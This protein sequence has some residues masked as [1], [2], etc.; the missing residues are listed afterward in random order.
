MHHGWYTVHV[1]KLN[2]RIVS[3]KVLSIEMD[4]AGCDVICDL[5]R[6]ALP[7]EFRY[8][9]SYWTKSQLSDLLK[10][11]GHKMRNFYYFCSFFTNF[12]PF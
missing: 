2:M 5:Q 10:F 1:K 4:L 7:I 11:I 12:S 8:S 6:W 3:L 9:D